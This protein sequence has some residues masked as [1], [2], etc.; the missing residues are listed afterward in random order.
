MQLIFNEETLGVTIQDNKEEWTSLSDFKPSF[1]LKG[2][3]VYFD[4]AEEFEHL[5]EGENRTR[6]IYTF[7]DFAFET[8]IWVEG[9]DEVYFQWKPLREDM[10]IDQV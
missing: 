6:S 8:S 1:L 7:Q 4:E 2:E 3:R 9:E 10:A 5:Y